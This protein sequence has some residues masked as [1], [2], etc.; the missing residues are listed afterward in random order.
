[1]IKLESD[2]RIYNPIQKDY[3][4]FLKTSQE[5][6]GEYTLVRVELAP[7][8][9]VGLHFHKT[10]SE[11]FRVLEGKLGVVL[12]GENHILQEGEQATA[13][14][15]ILHKF[16][17]PSDTESVV[18]ETE[19]RP[20]SEGFERSLQILYG[21]ARDGKT[22]KKGIPKNIF[23][24][25]ILLALGE[26]KLPGRYSVFEFLLLGFASVARRMGIDKKLQKYYLK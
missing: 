17:N 23:H 26:S 11:C 15:H 18:F 25:S 13:K 10:Y 12:S 2:R 16:Y 4:T 5:T 6:Q 20:A 14:P 19:L 3:V 22:N 7:K 21:L 9:G 24:L 8:G 1:M